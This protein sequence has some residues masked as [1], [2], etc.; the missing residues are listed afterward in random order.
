MQ[1]FALKQRQNQQFSDFVCQHYKEFSLAKIQ[2]MGLEDIRL[3]L[4]LGG[5]QGGRLRDKLFGEKGLS[6]KKLME[7]TTFF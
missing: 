6:M 1:T 5:I 4:I 2:D 3:H 7:F